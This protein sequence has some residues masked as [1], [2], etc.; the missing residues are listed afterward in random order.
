[1]SKPASRALK[2]KDRALVTVASTLINPF[3]HTLAATI[4]VE[5]VGEKSF[6][7]AL[8]SDRRVILVGWHGEVVPYAVATRR[9]GMPPF[10][11]MVSR[12][13]DGEIAAQILSRVAD[14]IPIRASSS[15]GG[16]QGILEFRHALRPG[17]SPEG[18]RMGGH[19]LDGPRGPRHKAKPGIVMMARM[20][21]ALIVPTVTGI[22]RR[23]ILRKAWDRHR[24]PLPFSRIVVMY[25]APLDF[26]SASPGSGDS[27]ADANAGTDRIEESLAQLAEAH[28]LAAAD[29]WIS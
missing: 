26:G 1:M 20:T 24:I 3:L 23:I 8:A 16:A 17:T 4:R 5:T 29:Y 11:G 19:A 25:G 10:T 27:D 12:S 15:R 2:P 21:N 14:F 6:L 22:S 7:D 9:I 18:L 13:K 28:P